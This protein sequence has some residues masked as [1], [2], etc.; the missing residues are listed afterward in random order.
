MVAAPALIPRLACPVD[1]STLVATEG[2]ARCTN[3]SGPPHVYPV[4][5]AGFL[6]VASADSPVLRVESTDDTY[7]HTQE[8][9]GRR[10]YD[11]Y[12]E[13]WLREIGA[14]S[15]LDA[16]CGI[17]STVQAM[18]EGGFDAL[19]VDMRGV[20]RYWQEAGHDPDAFV[21]G[22]VIALPFPD[23]TFDAVL[24]L[25]VIEHVGTTTGHVTLD[26]G[27]RQAREAFTAELTRVT[28]PGGRIL[29]ACPNKWFPLDVQHGPT[30]EGTPA[31]LRAK[32]FDRFKVNVHPTWGAYH[33]ASYG[34]LADWFGRDRVHP[35]PLTGYFGF[36]ALDRPNMP[37]VLAW[38]ARSWVDRL[39]AGLRRTP[40][41]PYVLAE[42]AC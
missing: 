40:L 39:P 25:G 22:D 2:G 29:V 28:R 31:P 15:V 34:D 21:V 18:R 13:P 1:R 7:A 6:E 37:S 19:G 8:S 23:D 24:T 32:V 27:W 26:D 12:L 38:A 3:P 11:A 4:G 5:S 30:D 16:G 20:T 33:L 36:S 10:V 14:D 42:I 17:G 9:G 41:N 35:L